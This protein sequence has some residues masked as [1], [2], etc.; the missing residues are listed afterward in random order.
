MIDAHQHVWRIGANDCS[1]PTA[2]DAPI[3]RDFLPEDW[4]AL[5]APLGVT[6]S[7][8]VQSQESARD[9]EWL[10]E[11]TAAHD[12]ILGVVGWADL[13]AGTAWPVNRWLKGLR[14]MV[15]DCAGDWLDDPALD[16]ALQ[17]MAEQGLV[18]DALIRPRH[19]ASLERLARRHPRLQIVIDH[20]AKPDITGG[21]LGDWRETMERLA[22]LPNV[23]CKLSGLLTEAAPGQEAEVAAVGEWLFARFGPERLIWG[24]DWPVLELAGSYAGWLRLARAIVPADAHDAVFGGNARRIYG[25]TVAGL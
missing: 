15:Q 13:K 25:L 11:L 20:A 24:S 2:A 1:W 17:A 23:A 5:A 6:G 10:L 19:L 21:G 7:V 12:F 9:T 18:F 3:H 4:R 22:M 16:P 8:L 14:P